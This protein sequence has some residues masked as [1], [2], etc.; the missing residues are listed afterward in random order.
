MPAELAGDVVAVTGTT[1]ADDATAI[2]EWLFSDAA[3]T[4][5]DL[6]GCTHL[7]GAV[8]Q[9]LLQA[10][11]ALAALPADPYLRQLLAGLHVG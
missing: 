1:N 4:T 3:G 8:L 7:H 6:G 11:P 10:R 2:A 9:V 5:I